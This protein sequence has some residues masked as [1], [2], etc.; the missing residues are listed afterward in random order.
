M[1]NR[2][3]MYEWS[4][5]H[6]DQ[7]RTWMWRRY[8]GLSLSCCKTSFNRLGPLCLWGYNLSCENE[9]CLSAPLIILFSFPHISSHFCLL[10]WGRN[11][12]E[13]CSCVKPINIHKFLVRDLIFKARDNSEFKVVI[14]FGNKN[15]WF[16]KFIS[17][18]FSVNKSISRADRRETNLS[19]HYQRIK[20]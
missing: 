19:P 10:A 14:I 6:T 3:R 1:D 5:L 13:T 4:F 15:K 7:K 11:K 18:F 2:C 20:Q 8:R 17:V 9:A 16:C 12:H